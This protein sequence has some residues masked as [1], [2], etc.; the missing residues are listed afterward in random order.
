MNSLF[1]NVYKMKTLSGFID[2][3]DS[4]AYYFCDKK[5]NVPNLFI[6]FPVKSYEVFCFEDAD[7]VIKKNDSLPNEGY[8]LNVNEKIMI[9]YSDYN[10]V[11]YALSTLKNL[12]SNNKIPY[13]EIEDKPSIKIRGYMLDISRDKV[14][15]LDTIKKVIDLMAE[16]KMNHLEFY[17]EG[18]SF[19]YKSFPQYLEEEGYITLEE[20]KE[21]QDYARDRFIDFVPNQNGFGHMTSWLE[22]DELKDLAVCPEG[23]ELWGRWREP[24]TL[25]PLN[26]R[27]LDLV[28]KMYED[29]LP[30]TVSSY[31][32]MNFDEPFEL[33]MGLTKDM[34]K[35]ELYL[36]FV[37]KVY[38]EIKKY[39]KTPLIWGDVL[40]RHDDKWD[41]LPKDM[42]FIDW[43]YDANYP[44]YSH[45]KRLK[46]KGV[47]FMCAPGTTSW[48]SF[49][50]RYL[51]WYE[52][53]KNAIDA[54]FAFDGEGVILT[55][56][57][58]FGHLQFLNTSYAPLIYMGVYS[59]SHKEG[60]ILKVRDY[61]NK[62][63]G[64]SD[65]LIGDILLDLNH[66]SRYDVDYAGNG[67]RT[68]YTFMWASVAMGD[69]KIKN[70]TP[71]E[72]FYNKVKWSILPYKKYVMMNRFFDLKLE[73]LEL[74]E[75][76]NEEIELVCE[77]IKQTITILKMIISLSV[78]LNEN[79]PLLD[80]LSYL[81]SILDGKDDYLVNQERLWLVRNKRSGFNR[82]KAR[83]LGFFNLVEETNIFLT[84]RGTL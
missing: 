65:N 21:A 31:F 43:G 24:S 7:I 63:L 50:G 70:V 61:L 68:F 29:M 42:I 54:I 55:D 35:E 18:F 40:V 15:T 12:I 34:D 45:A 52:N 76:N 84:K 13:C 83:L 51:D 39:N 22:K 1:T 32:N 11:F 75:K 44:F 46:E 8:L 48:S 10:G 17:V 78:S 72:C 26:P 19:E 73:E 20:Y 25:N 74:V 56:W 60:T 14:C 33:G 6:T 38:P 27:S 71:F 59:W 67:S 77:E 47:K 69:A 57:G 81:K 3:K 79:L 66:Y 80:R 36:D 64:D 30:H 53:I 5:V 4:F 16:L 23:I 62:Y 9:E 2:V 28:K 58:D 41:K 49:F 37:N 82:S